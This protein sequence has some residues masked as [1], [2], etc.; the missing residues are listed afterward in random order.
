MCTG[1]GSL[2]PAV[3]A[4]LDAELAWCADND[5]HANGVLAARFPQAPNQSPRVQLF[6]RALRM[7]LKGGCAS[8]GRWCL[9]FGRAWSSLL[10]LRCGFIAAGRD[11]GPLMRGSRGVAVEEGYPQPLQLA[12]IHLAPSSP[13][14]RLAEAEA[15]GM[16][17]KVFPVIIGGDFN[18]LPAGDPEPYKPR[19]AR[20]A[21]STAAPPKHWKK[22]G[23][24]TSAP[25][26][27]ISPSQSG[28]PANCPTAA[29][30]STPPCPPR[31]SPA[32]R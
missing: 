28:T 11:P 16:M 25:R 9:Q 23:S 18:A 30:G 29:T 22:P 4:V 6:R 31:Q 26:P 21:S 19:G 7:E 8:S 3:M 12:S 1:Y 17:A 2:D 24:S 10:R 20:G 13:A 15:L 32:T 27:E 5:P 14:I